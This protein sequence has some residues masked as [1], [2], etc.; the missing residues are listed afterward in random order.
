M[1]NKIT[2]LLVALMLISCGSRDKIEIFSSQLITSL[3]QKDYKKLEVLFSDKWNFKKEVKNVKSEFN[4]KGL[5]YWP[6]I[7]AV[8]YI[9]YE[10]KKRLHLFILCKDGNGK[11]FEIHN[12]E[13]YAGEDYT[14]ELMSG[15]FDIDKTFDNKAELEKFLEKYVEAQ[16]EDGTEV[17]LIWF[18]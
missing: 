7:E 18:D 6:E 2:I 10:I 4:R 9:V 13:G 3:A 12:I 11:Y 14:L 1:K 8:G 17:E 15:G 16:K 5:E